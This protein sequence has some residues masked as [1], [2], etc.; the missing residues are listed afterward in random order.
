MSAWRR[1]VHSKAAAV[2]HSTW[3]FNTRATDVHLVR[4]DE[5]LPALQDLEERHRAGGRRDHALGV[6][7][8]IALIG[9]ASKPI[10][11]R[12]GMS[13]EVSSGQAAG[14]PT[15][16]QNRLEQDPD[17]ARAPAASHGAHF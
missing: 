12:P 9:N 1:S 16:V 17:M 15:N 4:V 3:A 13:P 2:A 8:A 10:A 6:R 7:S 14:P 5:L 11:H